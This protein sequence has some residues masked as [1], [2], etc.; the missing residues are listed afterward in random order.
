MSAA[1][2][3]TPDA[4]ELSRETTRL[5][6]SGDLRAAITLA[7]D[8]FAQF[9][10]SEPVRSALAWVLYDRDIRRLDGNTDLDGLRNGWRTCGRLRELLASDPY[11]TYS[12]WIPAVLRVSAA[13]LGCDDGSPQR[14]T[15]AV[16]KIL[17]EIDASKL[18]TEG[19]RDGPSPM[20]R[21]ALH[22]TK[23]LY[24]LGAW[25]ELKQACLDSL[26]RMTGR[27]DTELWLRHRLGLALLALDDPKAALA[28]L[29]H[30][31]VRKATQWWA[32]HNVG[33][34]RAGAGDDKGATRAFATALQGGQLHM[35]TRVMIALADRLRANGDTEAADMH[36]R[37]ARQIRIDQGWGPDTEIDAP[38][39]ESTSPLPDDASRLEALWVE[40]TARPRER[41]RV[42]KVFENGGAGFLE[43]DC[44]KQ[45]Y[46]AMSRGTDAPT[47]G[48]RV[49]C[50][51]VPSFD[52]KKQ[53]TSDKA[54]D[55]ETDPSS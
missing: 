7:E 51:V 37:V 2:P 5:R 16:R 12:A 41:G 30:V 36:H 46:F 25:R 23:A 45:V 1:L 13:M 47:V 40:L 28:Y 14:R 24:R 49:S 39:G 29:E 34:A 9:P 22:L 4:W 54:V 17:S 3:A 50:R 31:S 10:D 20:E 26:P 38:L 32:H 6:K 44:G 35:K 33:R 52:P 27:R 21:H 55:L 19:F 53:Q 43:L 48:T 11:G 8:A 15:E 42:L 18:S